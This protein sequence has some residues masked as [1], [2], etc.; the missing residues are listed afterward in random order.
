MYIRHCERTVSNNEHPL[1]KHRN[2]GSVQAWKRA[3]GVEGSL[4]L[5]G[6]TSHES[7]SVE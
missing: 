6:D 1:L 3:S 7:D 4:A 5:K 2:R